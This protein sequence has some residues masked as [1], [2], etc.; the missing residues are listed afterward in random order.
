MAAPAPATVPLS[1]AT[2]GW[3]SARIAAHQVAGQAR[4]LEEA[5][6]VAMEQLADDVL[7]VAAGAER[8]ARA[9]EHHRPHLLAR[10]AR[11][12]EA[13]RSARGRPRRSASSGVSGRSRRER[14]HR[15][16][17]VVAEA[18]GRHRRVLERARPGRPAG[19][20]GA[21]GRRRGTRASSARTSRRWRGM[22]AA[23][24]AGGPRG[25][26]PHADGPPV[27]RAPGAAR[28]GPGATSRST[29]PVTLPAVT[30]SSR[31]S[32]PGVIPSGRRSS[33]ASTSNWGR[34]SPSGTRRR[35]SRSSRPWA[36]SSRTQTES[37]RAGSAG[38]AR[39]L[40][41]GARRFTGGPPPRSRP[42]RRP[43]A[44]T[45]PRRAPWREVLAHALAVGL[46]DAFARAPV[47][48]LVGH[49]DDEAGHGRPACR[50][51]PRPRRA[52]CRAPGRTGATKSPE[53]MRPSRFQPIWPAT[54]SSSPCALHAVAVAARAARATSGLHG[55]RRHS[56][57]RP[58]VHVQ[59]LAGDARAP[60]RR[61]GTGR[62]RPPP[63]SVTSRFC[64]LM[65]SRC[66][67]ISAGG[68]PVFSD[69]ARDRRRR[70]SGCPR[71]PGR[72]R[73]RSRPCCATSR[74][75]TLVRPST[76]CLLAA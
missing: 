15:A 25:G 69:D 54:N 17:L 41:R 13:S 49:V 48:A 43:R 36:F 6:R 58:A 5:L 18:R 51:P 50:P 27:A 8:A 12:A 70:S 65:S 32:S 3:G 29:M 7:H 33:W 47:L 1:E 44:A 35:T 38:V 74:A 22:A 31:V 26:E 21:P 53:T 63:R 46:A 19:P 60:P 76:P 59:R 37:A 30:S 23:H 62:G 56:H 9:G 45:S 66:L 64:G 24:R 68:R 75:A 71:S 55:V 10:S 52:R 42:W 73:S 11:R 16:R 39:R 28:R 67:R 2:I 40:A 14:G 72:P 20:A 61:T 34:V 4:E 57:H